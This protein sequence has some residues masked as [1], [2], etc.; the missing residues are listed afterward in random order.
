MI[1]KIGAV[2]L[3]AWLFGLVFL[4]DVGDIKHLPLLLGLMLVLLG[5]LKARDAALAAS[6]GASE[7]V[8][9]L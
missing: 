7:P 8:R 4:N 5:F 2:L 3:V 6:R 9:K 1:L